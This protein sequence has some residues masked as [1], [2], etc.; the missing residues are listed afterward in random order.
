MKWVRSPVVESNLKKRGYEFNLQTD[1]AIADIDLELSKSHQSRV[2]RMLD[3]NVVLSY[4]QSMQ[5][6]GATFPMPILNVVKRMPTT[7]PSG[8]HRI[9]A[10][11][12]IG[13]KHI[14]AYIVTVTRPL[15]LDLLP[16]I[17]NTWESMAPVTKEQRLVNAAYMIDHHSMEVKEAA[18]QFGLRYEWLN[19]YLRQNQVANQIAEEGV[20]T[21]DIPRNILTK[22]SPLQSN[23]KV[24]AATANFIAKNN[25]IGSEADDVIDQVK[26]EK[27]E[28]NQLSVIDKWEKAVNRRRLRRKAPIKT[29]VRSN[30]LRKV[31]RLAL[32]V[33]SIVKSPGKLDIEQLADKFQLQSEDYPALLKNWCLIDG[34]VGKLVRGGNG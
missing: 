26:K 6:P 27:T 22:L 14:D 34:I 31:D 24:L 8:L 20:A 30:F 17:V 2:G 7:I 5:A 13:E 23:H 9:S 10:A 16:R 21:K 1:F 32:F 12:L 25:I 29:S 4:A 18:D 33:S 15:D 28:A 19:A 3:D 11:D